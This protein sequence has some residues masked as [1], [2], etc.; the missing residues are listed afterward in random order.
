MTLQEKIDKA[1][2][3]KYFSYHRNGNCTLSGYAP[4]DCARCEAYEKKNKEDDHANG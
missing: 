4:F 1:K 2:Q 3:C